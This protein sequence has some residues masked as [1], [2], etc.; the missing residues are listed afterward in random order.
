MYQ[1][2]NLI[3]KL[4]FWGIVILL[5]LTRVGDLLS[6]YLVSPDL[7][8]ELNHM[9]SIFGLGWA[10]LISANVIGTGLIIYLFHYYIFRYNP[11]SA[12][13]V[14]NLKEFISQ[15][16]FNRPDKFSGSFYKLSE[17]GASFFADLGYSL[18]RMLIATGIML[19]FNNLMIA[20]QNQ[21]YFELMSLS[22]YS[23]LW[24]YLVGFVF[25]M[26]YFFKSIKN[27][28]QF[29]RTICCINNDK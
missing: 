27:E 19:I 3:Q 8:K 9:E 17:N 20:I 29:A 22:Q 18:P 23:W 1:L 25:G 15:R 28:Y 13:E 4:K 21:Y 26:L 12:V 7:S 11:V 14:K 24:I 5:L 10:G 16:Y 2:F 6:I